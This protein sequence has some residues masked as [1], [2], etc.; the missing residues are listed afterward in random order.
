MVVFGKVRAGAIVKLTFRTSTSR[1]TSRHPK[2]TSHLHMHFTLPLLKNLT[3]SHHISEM[4]QRTP[5]PSP[6]HTDRSRECLDCL[7]TMLQDGAADAS[8]QSLLRG[9]VR[10]IIRIST[11]LFPTSRTS[12]ASD[13]HFRNG[14]IN[15]LLR[16]MTIDISD[17]RS[18]SERRSLHTAST[19]R[20]AHE[21]RM[22][23]RRG[24]R[25]V[26]GE[27]RGLIQ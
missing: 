22:F 8:L 13:E 4:S 14:S 17:L 5:P 21:V 19:L 27:W 25:P 20:R 24:C 26:L 3:S 18:W 15:T 6:L 12:A 23:R 10:N 2:S 9:L 11:R 1:S 7:Q 16:W